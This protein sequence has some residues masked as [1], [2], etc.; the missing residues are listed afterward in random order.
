MQGGKFLSGFLAAG[1]STLGGPI[2]NVFAGQASG[3][4]VS[5]VLGGV[6]SVAGGGKF[7]NGAATGAFAYAEEAAEEENTHS[8][9][10]ADNAPGKQ[11]PAAIEDLL[12]TQL[13]VVD[14]ALTG[15]ITVS[16]VEGVDCTKVIGQMRAFNHIYGGNYGFNLDIE[17]FHGAGMSIADIIITNW[18]YSALDNGEINTWC[19]KGC[20][21]ELF[22]GAT[23]TTPAHELGHYLGLGHSGEPSSVMGPALPGRLPYPTPYEAQELINAYRD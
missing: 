16:C 15:T 9:E 6:A 21:M 17:E 2:T 1:V 11:G 5:A 3:T 18:N 20:L 22:N 19:V 4:A 10:E 7:A 12:R 13:H 14:N 8:D 23:N